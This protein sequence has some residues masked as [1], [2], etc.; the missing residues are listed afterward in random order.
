MS[1]IRRVSV[2]VATDASE[3]STDFSEVVNG[4]LLS[5]ELV[6]TDLAA[7]ADF[8]ITTDA[9]GQAIATLTNSGAS[10]TWHPRQATHDILGAASLYA[11]A[12]EPVESNIPIAND[13]I[14]IV[15]DEGGV[16]KSGVFHFWIG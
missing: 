7:G 15:T 6:D 1:Y 9:H 16:T 10:A 14:K 2:T 5:I 11:A 3:D 8:V 12:G 4:M 13:R